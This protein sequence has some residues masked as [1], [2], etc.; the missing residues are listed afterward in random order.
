MPTQALRGLAKEISV[1]FTDADGV[2]VDPG[3]VTVT[4][5]RA[6]GT[7]VTPPT[8]TGTGTAAREVTLS[9]AV[10]AQVDRLRIVWT[11]SS[12]GLEPLVTT[13]EVLGDLLFSIAEA[14]VW[15]GAALAAIDASVLTDARTRIAEAFHRICGVAFGTRY[16]L[17]VVTDCG[18]G[19][20][21]L[22]NHDTED[23]AF[24]G[25][26]VVR[27][28]ALRSVETRAAIGGT[29]T[30]YTVEQLA[31]LEALPS[32]TLVRGSG[33]WPS[34]T[35]RTRVGFE[36]GYA[37]VPLEVRRAALRLL[38]FQVIEND[39]PSRATSM[40]SEDGTFT[41]ATAGMRGAWFGLPEV[42]SVLDRFRVNV[43]VIR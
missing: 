39:I 18:Y 28:S 22:L 19:G 27:L 24:A 14:L 15:D 7:V 8:V 41:L 26:P 17:G 38:R 21:L 4:I 34:G 37:Q 40:N 10:T 43:P 16:G 13:V 30:A 11:P 20:E 35:R 29:W 33:S 5:T 23:A 42:D 1:T 3:V 2:A 25:L 31:A 12:V 9:A 36:H 6:D 32:G